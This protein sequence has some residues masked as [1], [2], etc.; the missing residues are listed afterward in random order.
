MHKNRLWTCLALAALMLAVDAG[1]ALAAN[2]ITVPNGASGTCASGNAN[3][4]RFAGNCGAE[5]N[6][7][8][9]TLT[10]AY[11]QEN[12]PSAETAYRVRLYANLLRLTMAGSDEFDL[13]AAYDG[14]DPAAGASSGNAAIRAEVQQ[15][16]ALKQLVFFVRTDGGSEVSTGAVNVSNGWHSIEFSWVRS[17]G[18]GNNNGTLNW[19]IDG[20][21]QTA[22]TGIDNDT[23]VVN[24]ARW[25]AVAGLEASTQGLIWMD[26]F[27]SQR[28]GYIG[29]AVPFPTDTLTSNPAW[30]EIQGIYQA[31]LTSG[32]AIGSY[33]GL[34]KISRRQMSVFVIRAKYGSDFVPPAAVGMFADV[35][36]GTAGF[37]NFIEQV[38]NDGIDLGC[39]GG[40]FCPD[41]NMDRAIMSVWLLKAEHGPGY[42]PPACTVATFAD[43]PCSHPLSAFI[44]Q[45]ATEAITLGCGGGNYCPTVKV[46]RAE[47]AIF[48]QRTYNCPNG[49]AGITPTERCIN[50]PQVGP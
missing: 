7:N 34:L 48:L 46:S 1:A 38:A 5:V 22:L 12:N 18:P 28:S 43:V 8:D 15:S 23:E 10:P 33:G 21:P 14:A 9:A 31:G 19:W 16:G 40:N 41:V 11:V 17:T 32:S 27:A 2:S 4:R 13:F 20:L 39:G 3:T 35:G 29:P 50:R 42:S 26:D 47:M 44:Y 25:G 30:R 24:Y 6:L 49:A 36:S 37:A 45:L